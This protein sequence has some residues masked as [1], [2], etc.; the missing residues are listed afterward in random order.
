MVKNI[1][2]F[3][4]RGTIDDYRTTLRQLSDN[5]QKMATVDTQVTVYG[6]LDNTET[7]SQKLDEY[8]GCHRGCVRCVTLTSVLYADLNA[9][10][11]QLPYAEGAGFDPE[12]GCLSGTRTNFINAIS[13]WVND[14][15][16]SQVLLLFGQAGTGK[17]SIAHEMAHRFKAVNRLT[18][19]FSFEHSRSPYLFFTTL[20]RDL[21]DSYPAF[22]EVLKNT[23]K[24]NTS[25]LNTRAYSNLFQCLLRDPLE[26]LHFIGPIFVIIDALDESRDFHLQS[27]LATRLSELPLNFRILITSRPEA[28]IVNAFEAASSIERMDMDD[29]VLAAGVDEDILLYLQANL[30]PSIVSLYSSELIQKAEGLFQWAAVVCDYIHRPSAGLTPRDCIRRLLMPSEMDRAP[31]H[32]DRLYLTVL[33]AQFDMEDRLIRCRFQSVMGLILASFEPLSMDDLVI[34]RKYAVDDDDEVVTAIVAPLA[35]LLSNVT[36][37]VSSLPVVPLHSS[38]REFLVDERRSRRFHIDLTEAHFHLLSL[39][40]L[41]MQETLHFNICG[42]NTS[43]L[44]NHDL[45]KTGVGVPRHLSYACRFWGGHLRRVP[46]N[47]NTANRLMLIFETQ[48]LFWFEALSAIGGMALATPALISLKAWLLTAPDFSN[49]SIITF[50]SP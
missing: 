11:K 27:F 29:P 47:M 22:K 8:G 15:E 1:T 34:L 17:S 23:I 7:I 31:N 43:Y 32:L 45:P 13:N 4:T 38:F 19:F 42:L 18:T 48:L 6:I 26:K 2:H 5:F 37:S 49:V 35:S 3:N 9:E 16:S 24:N 28:T 46:F 30:S 40:L 39:S 50:M 10:I 12:R 14:P 41:I 21:C 25:V 36:H 44:S 33:S 20:I